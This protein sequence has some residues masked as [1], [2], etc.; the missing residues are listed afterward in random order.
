MLVVFLKFANTIFYGMF[1][2]IVYN[3]KVFKDFKYLK[4]NLWTQKN[5]LKPIAF[6]L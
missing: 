6:S 1:N 3:A 4:L 2:G 5:I